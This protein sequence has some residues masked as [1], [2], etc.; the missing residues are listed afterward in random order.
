MWYIQGNRAKFLQNE[1]A[2][3]KLFESK[4]KALVEGIGFGKLD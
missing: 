4:G 2:S 3:M 1:G